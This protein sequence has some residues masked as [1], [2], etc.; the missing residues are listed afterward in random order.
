MGSLTLVPCAL[1]SRGPGCGTQGCG[2]FRC[3]VGE[4]PAASLWGCGGRRGFWDSGVLSEPH[5]EGVS[6]ALSWDD[7][8]SGVFTPD[9]WIR[10]F[11]FLSLLLVQKLL[12]PHCFGV[13]LLLL[14][15]RRRTFCVILP[16]IGVT[17]V[18]SFLPTSV[19]SLSHPTNLCPLSLSSASSS[20]WAIL[21]TEPSSERA[22]RGVS[23]AWPW[24]DGG[25]NTKVSKT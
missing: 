18:I 1:L 9:S 12:L 25:R 16:T 20:L 14:L 6:G 10:V 21:A 8:G 17:W 2:W 7:L 3:E 19:K 15:V 11:S 22:S 4:P 24:E 23:H 5:P 13:I